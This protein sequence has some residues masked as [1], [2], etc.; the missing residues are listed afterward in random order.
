[1]SRSDFPRPDSTYFYL[2]FTCSHF[3]YRYSFIVYFGFFN[4]KSPTNLLDV[5]PLSLIMISKHF[6]IAD[7]SF[8]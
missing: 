2:I 7:F 6:T 4:F 8:N 1:M 3:S 5:Q